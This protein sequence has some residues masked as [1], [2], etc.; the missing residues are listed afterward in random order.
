LVAW[1]TRASLAWCSVSIASS[2]DADIVCFGGADK[3]EAHDSFAGRH[4]NSACPLGAAVD[5]FLLRSWAL[6]AEEEILGYPSVELLHGR[7]VERRWNG[8]PYQQYSGPIGRTAFRYLGVPTEWGSWHLGKT[9]LYCS[10]WQCGGESCYRVFKDGEI[11]DWESANG[12]KRQPPYDAGLRDAG[13][14]SRGCRLACSEGLESAM[15]EKTQR[16]RRRRR[17]GLVAGGLLLLVVIAVPVL[18]AVVRVRV[19]ADIHNL[20]EQAAHDGVTLDHKG[21]SF[22]G[23][24]MEM[25]LTIT[26]PSAV[27]SDGAWQGPEVIGGS[28]SFDNPASIAFNVS[29]QHRVT[30]GPVKAVIY[31][32]NADA[33]VEVGAVGAKA[34]KA[35]LRGIEVDLTDGLN[36]AQIE[37]LDLHA[38]PLRPLSDAAIATRFAL[39]LQTLRLPA[40]LTAQL[41]GLDREVQSVKVRGQLSGPLGLGPAPQVLAN[42]RDGGGNLRIETLALTWSALQLEATG[43]VSLDKALRPV[44]ALQL[45]IAGLPTFLQAL[46]KQGQTDRS[47]LSSYAAAVQGLARPR[48]GKEGKWVSVPLLLRDGRAYLKLFFHEIPLMRLQPVIRQG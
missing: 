7:T 8:K 3:E 13:W 32:Q 42:W 28:T 26:R 41:P 46:R 16:R 39:D 25:A 35:T 6:R 5:F 9:G 20:Q 43:R 27:W 11:Y 29:G 12:S 47:V 33:L 31:T 37:R 23:F 40:G 17:W 38:N 2:L 1:P 36:E 4:C 45:Q 21:L 30:A 34:V 19:E 22:S 15:A 44:G 14:Q 24:P 10:R 48:S 18:W